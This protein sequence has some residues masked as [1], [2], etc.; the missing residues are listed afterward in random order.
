MISRQFIYVRN[1]VYLLLKLEKNLS[2]SVQMGELIR[3]VSD[4]PSQVAGWI[5]NAFWGSV[6]LLFNLQYHWKQFPGIPQSSSR[7]KVIGDPWSV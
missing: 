2:P 7:G 1:K 4:L 5:I 3:E 6:T